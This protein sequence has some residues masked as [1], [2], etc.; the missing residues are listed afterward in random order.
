MPR[1]DEIIAKRQQAVDPAARKFLIQEWA[2]LHAE[3]PNYVNIWGNSTF[4]IY[5]T[6]IQNF[7]G[8]AAYW[9]HILCDPA[10]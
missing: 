8:S 6:R 4:W 3:D 7:Q 2:L 5:N 10:W 9:E 1:T